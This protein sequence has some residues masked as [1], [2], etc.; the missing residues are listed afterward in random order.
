MP[1]SQLQAEFE[2]RTGMWCPRAAREWLENLMADHGFTARELAIAWNARTLRWDTRRAAP[3]VVT[4][5]YEAAAAYL[6]W[7]TLTAYVLA[8][9][10]PL[11]LS[12]E[13]T[14]TGL[15]AVAGLALMYLGCCWM[16]VRFLLSP[17]RIAQRV[18]RTLEESPAHPETA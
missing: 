2:Q 12:A 16:A 9:G 14:S 11:T 13:R 8:A 18:G 7:V 15:L 6:V 17:R 4:A 5:W 3:Q 10:L 1:E